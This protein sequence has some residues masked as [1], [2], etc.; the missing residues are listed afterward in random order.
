MNIR[1]RALMGILR[2]IHADLSRPH[3]FAFERVG[4]LTCGIAEF[5]STELL[6]LA[7]TWHTIDDADYL[8]DPSVGACIGPTA[9]RK[10]LQAA[11]QSTETILHVHRHDH[12]GQP[13][14]SAL[15]AQSMREFVPGFFNACPSRPHG[16]IV[17][18]YDAGIGAIWMR[19]DSVPIPI[20]RFEFVGAPATRWRAA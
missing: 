19:P 4:F 7:Q 16:A 1:L 18:S 2:E 17:L 14:F 9:F 8:N 20:H 13:A 11:H 3:P 5:H 10:I 15:D 12:R 6:L